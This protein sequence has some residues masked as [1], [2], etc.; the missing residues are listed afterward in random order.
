MGQNNDGYALINES[1]DI[2]LTVGF[3]LCIHELVRMPYEI[4][5]QGRYEE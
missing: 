5:I 1:P 3:I 2:T 4:D